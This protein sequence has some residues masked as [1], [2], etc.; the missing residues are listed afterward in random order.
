MRVRTCTL[1]L[2]LLLALYAPSSCADSTSTTFS[3]CSE[4]EVGDWARILLNHTVSPAKISTPV[5]RCSVLVYQGEGLPC[6]SRFPSYTGIVRHALANNSLML[7]FYTLCDTAAIRACPCCVVPYWNSDFRLAVSRARGTNFTPI[8]DIN[9]TSLVFPRGSFGG[10]PTVEALNLLED[11]AKDLRIVSI[12]LEGIN[13]GNHP[14]TDKRQGFWAIDGDSL[15]WIGSLW[16]G[17][18]DVQGVDFSYGF[19]TTIGWASTPTTW[20]T[21]HRR[22]SVEDGVWFGTINDPDTIV[23]EVTGRGITAVGVRNPDGSMHRVRGPLPALLAQRRYPDSTA[24]ANPPEIVV[25]PIFA[26]ATFSEPRMTGRD[27]EQLSDYWF[28]VMAGAP[29]AQRIRAWFEGDSVVFTFPMPVNQTVVLW[30]DSDLEEDFDSARLSE[31]DRGYI[32][33]P[34]VMDS[35][36]AVTEVMMESAAGRDQLVPRKT[37][38]QQGNWRPEGVDCAI[39]LARRDIGFEDADGITACG[40]AAEAFPDSL[41]PY[42]LDGPLVDVAPIGYGRQDPTTWITLMAAPRTDQINERRLKRHQE[43]EKSRK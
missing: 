30:F 24:P 40:F 42:R 5:E 23:M 37:R 10:N 13:I 15:V 26:Q 7:W 43:L 36:I 3:R 9:L 20:L 14:H 19:T 6:L 8:Q 17:L 16:R 31:D 33:R 34:N 11:P 18:Y 35:T 4:E 12:T 32:I 38:A 28:R 25:V 41:G 2:A 29:L 22:F 1:T 21:Y 27:T 39:R